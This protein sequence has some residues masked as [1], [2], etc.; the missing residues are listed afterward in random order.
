MP[1]PVP[2]PVPL[3]PRAVRP[4]PKPLPICDPAL[5][6]ALAVLLFPSP[7]VFALAPP[8]MIRLPR[9]VLAPLVPAAPRPRP[10]AV[11]VAPAS[12]RCSRSSTARRASSRRR[13]SSAA[14]R[15]AASC[16]ASLSSSMASRSLLA[17]FQ[18][19]LRIRR[20]L[21]SVWERMRVQV[22]RR[23][24]ALVTV[25]ETDYM[26]VYVSMMVVDILI[27]VQDL[28][29]CSPWPAPVCQ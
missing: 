20:W 21:C 15:C 9:V 26:C 27:Q 1:G 14:R 5:E 6:L 24:E 18:S 12:R 4:A 17:P 2:A 22:L 11:V 7:D 13:S 3:V 29:P 19:L 10:V 28:P 25:W 23:V 8:L 16:S